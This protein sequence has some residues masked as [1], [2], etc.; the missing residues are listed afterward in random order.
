MPESARLYSRVP[1]LSGSS[2]D[3]VSDL[4]E[5]TL[6]IVVYT[7]PTCGF[8]FQLKN[9]LRQRG[10]PFTEYDISQ[11]PRRAAEMVRLSG[12][13]G[14]P[15]S[16]VDGQAVLGADISRINQLLAQRSHRPPRLGIAIAEAS[17]IAAKRG[18]Q[19]PDG[20]YVGRV[21]PA[22][23]AALSDVRVGDVIVE[24]DGQPV[25]SDRDV[26]RI[27]KSLL[28]DQA[29]DVRVWRNGQHIGL[30]ARL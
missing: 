27:G 29:V 17:R 8:C 9:Y 11:D 5:R 6:S 2:C 21:N 18:I 13:Q 4:E 28:Y 19:L 3:D 7:T 22:S 1:P 14:V 25:R 20:A 24:L 12:Q 26:H 23:P 30:R 10:I 15:V 16:V